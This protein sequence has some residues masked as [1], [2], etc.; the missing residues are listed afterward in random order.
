MDR[1]LTAKV[2][3]P[4]NACHFTAASA[5]EKSFSISISEVKLLSSSLMLDEK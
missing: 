3:W 4:E 2:D 5:K 1:I